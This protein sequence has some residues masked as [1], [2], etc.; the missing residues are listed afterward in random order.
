M[1]QRSSLL[2]VI[3]I[4]IILES[5]SAT[6]HDDHTSFDLLNAINVLQYT[7]VT[8]FIGLCGLLLAIAKC[9]AMW[10]HH[11][12]LRW[13]YFVYFIIFS[14]NFV[15][16]ALV[17]VSRMFERQSIVL[18]LVSTATL[19]CVR[20]MFD[21][22]ISIKSKSVWTKPAFMTKVKFDSLDNQLS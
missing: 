5:T 10:I 8:V 9:H 11:D 15:S 18:G 7:E 12:D 17:L 6:G 19:L 1:A 3:S 22:F 4:A 2:I 21:L 13:R 14:M 20:L 16:N